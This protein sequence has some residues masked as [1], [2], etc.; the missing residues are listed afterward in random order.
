M[1][2]NVTDKQNLLGSAAVDRIQS[3]TLSLLSKFGDRIKSIDLKVEDVNGPRG[4]IDKLCRV[5]VKLKR[6]AD[7]VITSQ[8]QKLSRAI[9]AAI[10]RAS[11]SVNRQIDRRGGRGKRQ[12]SR[13]GA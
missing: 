9:S 7:V 8:D 12:L 1:K 10:E 2:F 6:K 4:G 13:V 3:R 5:M 11:R